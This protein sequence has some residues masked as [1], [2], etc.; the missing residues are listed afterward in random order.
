ML[1]PG[2]RTMGARPGLAKSIMWGA[3]SSEWRVDREYQIAMTNPNCPGCGG[4][5]VQKSRLRLFVV[6]SLLTASLAL[7]TLVPYFWAPGIILMLAGL[8]LIVWATLGKGR[9][10]RECKRFSIF[11]GDRAMES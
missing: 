2:K 8:Y 1:R 10:C 5:M 11:S 4:E 3:G 6:G 9:W 7:A